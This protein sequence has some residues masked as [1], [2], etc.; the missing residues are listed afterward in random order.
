MSI[1]TESATED[2]NEPEKTRW[3]AV[4]LALVV[5]AVASYGIMRWYQYQIPLGYFREGV[6][7]IRSG[8][9]DVVQLQTTALT[10]NPEFS[11]HRDYLEAAFEIYRGELDK[12]EGLLETAGNDPAV[13]PYALV[14]EGVIALQ[15]GDL[16]KAKTKAQAALELDAELPE[17]NELKRG[18]EN[19]E[20]PMTRV[21]RALQGL[22]AGDLKTVESEIKALMETPIGDPYAKFIAGVALMREN[23]YA[24]ALNAFGGAVGNPQLAAETLTLSG[25]ALVYLNQRAEAES[26]FLQALSIDDQQVDSHRWLASLYYDMGAHDHAAAHLRRISEL[27]PDDFRPYR[28]LGLMNKDFEDFETAVSNYD[29]ALERDPSVLV[30]AEILLEKSQCLARLRKYAEARETLASPL[31]QEVQEPVFV[32]MMKGTLAECLLDEGKPAEASQLITEILE[33]DPANL[34]ALVL[35]GTLLQLNNNFAE[36]VEVLTQAVNSD[37][38]DYTARFKL[39]QV[40]QAQ[41]NSELAKASLERAEELKALREQFSRLHQEAAADLTNVDT[42]NAMGE[43]ALQLGRPDLAA[44]WFQSVLNIDPE[45]EQAKTRLQAVVEQLTGV[46][47]TPQQVPPQP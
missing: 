25:E 29:K 6:A 31:L 45:N 13:Q 23:N 30:R 14:A 26:L 37:P 15:R 7:G 20:Q 9:W 16:E 40:Y 28:Q 19:I 8:N 35:R 42:R 32:S 43:T 44:V 46:P 22:D 10:G 5:T 41:G 34:D 3:W 21:T 24:E 12:A 39:A 4:V 17:A 27:A 11:S 18:L 38:Y 36:A 2:S 33:A 47:A 1:F